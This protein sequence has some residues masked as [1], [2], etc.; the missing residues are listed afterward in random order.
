M[1]LEEFFKKVAADFKKPKAIEALAKLEELQ[2]GLMVAF[3]AEQ[4]GGMQATVTADATSEVSIE[5]EGKTSVSASASASGEA[6]IAVDKDALIKAE[7]DVKK[8]WA[9]AMAAELSEIIL[10]D[11]KQSIPVLLQEAAG[12]KYPYSYKSPDCSTQGDAMQI[13]SWAAFSEAAKKSDAALPVLL[14][15]VV[16]GEKLAGIAGNTIMASVINT[17]KERRKSLAKYVPDAEKKL[18]DKKIDEYAKG[19]LGLLAS[20]AKEGK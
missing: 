18:K 4:G 5:G 14:G 10:A 19:G 12:E 9:W 2:M 16:P 20:L 8:T 3:S 7:E 11:P 1:K 13:L 17:P 15:L 6:S